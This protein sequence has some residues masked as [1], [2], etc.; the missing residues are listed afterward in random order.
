ML[1]IYTLLDKAELEDIL[2]RHRLAP[3]NRIAQ[4]TLAKC[5]TEI[6]HGK[7]NATAIENLTNLLFDKNTNFADFSTD[8]ISEFAKFL[9]I[10]PKDT[11]LVDALVAT[12]L[13]ESKK[14][15]REFI[16]AGA[17]SI[18]GTKVNETLILN[19]TAIIKKGKNKFAVVK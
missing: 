5:I 8:E 15:A 16:A 4:K 2:E 18:N 11:D 10:I 14:K 7:D 12:G 6:V 17:I 9:P 1:K 3:E 19:Q 13:A